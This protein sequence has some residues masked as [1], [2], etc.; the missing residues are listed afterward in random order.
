MQENG[1]NKHKYMDRFINIITVLLKIQSEIK[2]DTAVLFRKVFMPMKYFG[3]FV[4][5]YSKTID[6]S[7]IKMYYTL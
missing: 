4:S 3:F 6:K 2:T 1:Y 7:G 5:I